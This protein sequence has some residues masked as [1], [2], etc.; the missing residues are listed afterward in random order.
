MV[1]GGIY[2]RAEDLAEE[3]KADLFAH[4]AR[5]ALFIANEYPTRTP[6]PNVPEPG[7]RRKRKSK[8]QDL[9][10]QELREKLKVEV[11]QNPLDIDELIEDP[12]DLE[13]AEFSKM[14]Y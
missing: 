13:L 5:E 7:R 14:G 3:I 1:C 2:N 9:H 8:T 12:T 6:Q 11:E 4:N 10:V